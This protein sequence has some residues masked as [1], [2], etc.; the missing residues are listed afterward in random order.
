M[1]FIRKPNHYVPAL[2]EVT[3]RYVRKPLKY[4]LSLLSPHIS[5]V[6]AETT[7][8]LSP[9]LFQKPYFLYKYHNNCLVASKPISY[10]LCIMLRRCT[11]VGDLSS[12]I[13]SQVSC[14]VKIRYPLMVKQQMLIP[15]NL[16]MFHN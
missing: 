10:I 11:F 4:M 8:D 13:V 12:L 2:A 3:S 7:R 5:S 16:S 6:V 9:Y 15:P 14:I 1:P